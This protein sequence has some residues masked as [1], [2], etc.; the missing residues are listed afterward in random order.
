LLRTWN[1]YEF[2]LVFLIVWQEILECSPYQRGQGD[3]G[4]PPVRLVNAREL[5]KANVRRFLINYLFN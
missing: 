5:R 4:G 1:F 3:R 2:F